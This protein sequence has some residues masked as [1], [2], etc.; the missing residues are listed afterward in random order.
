MARK[1]GATSGMPTWESSLDPIATRLREI[2][3]NTKE[4]SDHLGVL[5]QSV[6]SW[7]TGQTRPSLE[8]LCEISRFYNVTTDYILGLTN[9]KRMNTDVRA[10]CDKTGLWENVVELLAEEQDE[11]P[12]GHETMWAFF[13]NTVLG[14]D[15]SDYLAL[16]LLDLDQSIYLA[17]KQVYQLEE[18]I[19]EGKGLSE[20]LVFSYLDEPYLQNMENINYIDF[21][22]HLRHLSQAIDL[23]RFNVERQFRHLIDSAFP[24]VSYKE[25]SSLLD[26]LKEAQ[27][28]GEHHED[29]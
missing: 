8:N 12:A 20:A 15:F 19:K 13:V 24:D 10:I 6:N 21:S 11:A 3:P 1:K 2:I 9:V 27:K 16:F 17:N 22:Q 25:M 26:K 5:P 14:S 23:A 18:C 29:G 7:K 28:N 4:L